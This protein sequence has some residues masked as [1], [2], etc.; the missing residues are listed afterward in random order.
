MTVTFS[1]QGGGQVFSFA[2]DVTKATSA[3]ANV[4]R[5]LDHVPDIDISSPEGKAVD[6]LEAGHIV[7]KDV[8]FS[9]PTRYPPRLGFKVNDDVDQI[10]RC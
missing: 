3:T 8:Y 1:A 9:Y 6:H 7:F 4:T 10:G 5:L 2:P